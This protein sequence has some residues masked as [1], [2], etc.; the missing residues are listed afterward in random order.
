MV[1]PHAWDSSAPVSEA[2]PGAL[3]VHE[4]RFG[5]GEPQYEFLRATLEGCHEEHDLWKIVYFHYPPYVSSDWQAETLRDLLCPLL[6]E[7][8]VD[9]V[10]N[11]HSVVY[12]RSHPISRG[13]VAPS[14][15]AGTVYVVAGGARERP[16]WFHPRRAWHTAHALATPHFVQVAVGAG[17]LELKAIDQDGHVF[18]MHVLTK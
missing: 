15:D 5:P 12:E 16:D 13:A 7:H 11:S 10:F 6:E 9:L 18:D 1:R 8:G 14:G 4:P 2:S 17:T 3:R